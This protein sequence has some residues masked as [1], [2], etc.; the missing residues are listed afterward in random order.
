MPVS[1]DK[2]ELF[3]SAMTTTRSAARAMRLH[4]LLT[5]SDRT[6]YKTW[7]LSVLG[8]LV[9][10]VLLERVGPSLEWRVGHCRT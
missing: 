2:V 3:S 6:A 1:P 7:E 5:D 8:L 10:A 4:G 9:G